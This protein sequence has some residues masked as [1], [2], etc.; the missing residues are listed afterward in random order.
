MR[1]A[2]IAL[3][4]LV[5]ATV[6]AYRPALDAGFVYEDAKS[7]TFQ[8]V[9]SGTSPWRP[10]ALRAVSVGT[11]R[12][13]HLL[14]PKPFGFH[15]TNVLIHVLNGVLIVL[16]LR[17]VT[18]G[19]TAIATAGVFLLHPLNVQA[20]A[21]VSGRTELVALA[22]I[23]LACLAVASGSLLGACAGA[24]VA[25]GAKE[26]AICVF[27]LVPLVSWATGQPAKQ[28]WAMAALG[29]AAMV[30]LLS[31]LRW[32][33]PGAVGSE[34]G[35]L[36]YPALQAAAFWRYLALIVYPVGLTVEHDFDLVPHSVALAALLSV[37][38]LGVLAWK[39][40]RRMPVLAFALGWALLGVAVRFVMRLPDQ[41]ASEHHYY[42]SMVGLSLLSVLA[43][44]A[45]VTGLAALRAQALAD[46]G[47]RWLKS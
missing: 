31:L 38:G 28:R 9:V 41:P 32:V 30:G 16:L 17:K 13:N 6:L 12:L 42:A 27:G 46:A 19:Q 1:G 8:P 40:R 35:L 14:S 33:D 37:I 45:I 23:L 18:D 10:W 11:L 34:R 2:L 21:Y 29:V 20:V 26:S 25:I 43:V 4:L 44:D 24:L 36:G 22:G 7:V 39:V 3:L 5:S 47:A 15:L